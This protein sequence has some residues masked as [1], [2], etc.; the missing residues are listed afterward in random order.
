MSIASTSA[1]GSGIRELDENIQKYAKD[2]ISDKDII[3]VAKRIAKKTNESLEGLNQIATTNPPEFVKRLEEE[4]QRDAEEQAVFQEKLKRTI[5]KIKDQV[6]ESAA[7]REKELRESFEH[8]EARLRTDLSITLAEELAR[9]DDELRTTLLV[10]LKDA[11]VPLERA[12]L[13]Y[14]SRASRYANILVGLIVLL[15][16]LLIIATEM[17]FGWNIGGS[18]ILTAILYCLL[19]GYFV[20]KK[21][22]WSLSGMWNDLKEARIVKY[23]RMFGF[24]I[25][26]YEKIRIGI[27]HLEKGGNATK[28]LRIER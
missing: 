17:F 10:S 24:D 23:Y 28:T 9:K 13:S 25:D 4:A 11:F 26:Q 8:R 18:T 15:P 21:K 12:K 16:L 20:Y 22:E 14:E 6:E 19:Y 7:Q 2:V 3:R 5:F 1:A 27:E